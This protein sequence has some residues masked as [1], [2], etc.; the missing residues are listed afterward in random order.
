MTTKELI[1]TYSKLLGNVQYWKDR[2]D[3]ARDLIA[4]RI[5]RE[6]NFCN[7]SRATRYRVKE[8]RV[9]SHNR[10]AFSALRITV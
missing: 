6:G 10:R 8:T 3:I 1:H 4:K 5:M 9:R 2:A 7:G